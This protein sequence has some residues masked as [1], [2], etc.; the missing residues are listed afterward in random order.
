MRKQLAIVI[1]ASGSMF[2]P[3]SPDCT[4]DKVVEA[5]ESTQWMLDDIL[6][7]VRTSSDQ[8]AVSLWYFASSWAGLVGQTL[9]DASTS[10]FTVGIMKDVVADISN[11]PSTQGAVGNLT[12]IFGALRKTAD[13]MQS[14]PPA[15][16]GAPAPD[17]K[18]IIFFTDGEQTVAH[19]GSLTRAGYEA[20]Q[21]V[22]FAALLGG[23]AFVLNTQ[24]I[25]SE[26]LNA[27]LTDL[28]AQALAPASKAKVISETPNY[29][30][31]CSAA[32]M[33]NALQAVNNNGVLPLR[34]VPGA[35]SGLLW[36]QFRLPRRVVSSAVLTH[37]A[38]QLVN[39]Q[40]FEVDVDGITREL[41]CGLTWHQ[42]GRPSLDLVSPSGASFAPGA[43]STRL[44]QQ[45]WMLSFH[46]PNPEAGT[47]RVRVHGDPRSSPIRLNLMARGI[48][49]RFKLSAVAR[50]PAIAT[51]GKA[52]IVATPLVD[53]APAAG[54]F[55]AVAAVLGGASVT[56]DR[57]PDGSYSAEVPFPDAGRN[58]IRVEL[59]GKLDAGESVHRFEFTTVQVGR[60]GDP[61]LRVNP[62]RY[63][64]GQT[65]AV[66]VA[67]QDAE[68][69]PATQIR[70]G[71]GI[72]VTSF[73]VL[74]AS[75]ARAEIAVAPDAVAGAREVVT[76]H[77]Q[78]ET[79]TGIE[80]LVGRRPGEPP[81][82]GGGGRICCLRFDANGRVIAVVFCDGS[83][84]PVCTPSER[85]QKVLERARDLGQSV[86]IRVDAKGCLR[87][88]DVRS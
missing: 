14:N 41:V 87:E 10:D 2:H 36:E 62:R 22:S 3:A 11:Q 57:Q 34:P 78:A 56:L 32:I 65:Y 72:E 61:R 15:W 75:E 20:S 4:H 28:V 9:L 77:P 50:P 79:Y 31:D 54:E 76:Y 26:L 59:H 86:V 30:A 69:G 55:E 29:A 19:G 67:I 7:H 24:G 81:P 68:L 80:V 63:E 17:R 48:D 16:P 6:D 85:L 71:A 40:D 35:A 60:P 38:A 27:T 73:Q 39:H 49:R 58:L 1:D 74:G 84:V 83:T 5:V 37:V 43:P 13:W 82:H 18:S 64:P 46:V 47:W 51:P 21:G 42:P 53:D 12:D 52:E 66:D 70:F 25:G 44:L 33:T 45:G 8:W 23:R 88:V